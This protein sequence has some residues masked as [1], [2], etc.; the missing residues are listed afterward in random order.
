M[1]QQPDE[2]LAGDDVLPEDDFNEAGEFGEDEQPEK[3]PFWKREILL[4][5]TLPWLLGGVLLL[6][7]GGWFIFGTSHG[8]GTNQPSDADFSEVEHTLGQPVTEQPHEAGPGTASADAPA[9]LSASAPMPSPA[10]TREMMEDIRD[11]LNEREGRINTSI[12]VLQDSISKLSDA[13]KRDEAYAVET[14]NQLMAIT[15]KLAELETRQPST[16][17]TTVKASTVKAKTSS[18][19]AGMH[20]VSLENGMA[21]IKWQGSTWAVREGDQLGKV[22]IS[23]IDPATRSISTTGGVLR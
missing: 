10:G 16:P 9:T 18:P 7:A 15:A 19:I 8:S 4:G 5:Y 12:T 20:V 11:E 13:I 2:V 23:R 1:N 21:W 14:R 17:A 3:T 6:A 22:T